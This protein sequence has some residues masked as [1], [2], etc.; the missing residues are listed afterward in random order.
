M[1]ETYSELEP[2]EL[3]TNRRFN[4]S[5]VVVFIGIN[6]FPEALEI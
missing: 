5:A 1:D 3:A 2:T 6:R 4:T